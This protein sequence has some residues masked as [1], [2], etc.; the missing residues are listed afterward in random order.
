MRFFLIT[1]LIFGIFQ[2]HAAYEHA[3][4]IVREHARR[5]G[6]PVSRLVLLQNA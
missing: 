1:A 4:A 2:G 3:D 5:T 6:V